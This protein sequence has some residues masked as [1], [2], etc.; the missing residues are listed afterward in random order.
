LPRRQNS[1]SSPHNQANPALAAGAALDCLVRLPPEYDVFKRH[2]LLALILLV[3]PAL[4]S[5]GAPPKLPEN[6]IFL[7]TRDTEEALQRQKVAQCMDLLARDLSLAG[8]DLPQVLVVHVSKET[9]KAIGVKHLEVRRNTGTRPPEVYYELW[10]AGQTSLA[11]YT[12][13]MEAMLERHFDLNLTVA[14]RAQV[15]TRALRQL[16]ATVSAYGD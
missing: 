1:P 8:K 12:V 11:D 4:A 13:A 3:V 14:E 2:A 15:V 10:F 16:S 9:G 5:A 6:L 7:E